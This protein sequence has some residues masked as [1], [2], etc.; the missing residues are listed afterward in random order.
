[1]QILTDQEIKQ[2]ILEF[3]DRISIAR[4]KLE[5]LPEGFLPFQEHKK[6]EQKRYDLESEIKHIQKIIEIATGALNES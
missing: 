5:N 3:Q 6:R 2:D 4:Q 1:M